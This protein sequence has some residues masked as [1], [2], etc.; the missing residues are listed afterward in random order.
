VDFDDLLTFWH[1]LLQHK[2]IGPRIS[3]QLD[4][5]LVDE[6]QDTS[7]LQDRILRCLR[8][9]GRGLV[10]V[11]DDDQCIYGF[12]GATLHKSSA[13]RRAQRF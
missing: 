6:Y 11:G 1:R 7:P 10:L 8:P 3:G 2:R 9:Q 13:M 5:V 4:Y 12:R